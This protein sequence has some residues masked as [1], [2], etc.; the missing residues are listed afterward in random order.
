MPST[1]VQLNKWAVILSKI[2]EFCAEWLLCWRIWSLYWCDLRFNINKK[3]WK[4]EHVLQGSSSRAGESWGWWRLWFFHGLW[5]GLLAGMPLNRSFYFIASRSQFIYTPWSKCHFDGIQ[6]FQDVST[7]TLYFRRGWKST[8]SLPWIRQADPYECWRD[9]PRFSFIFFH[10]EEL[11]FIDD[12]EDF[13]FLFGE[14]E[15]LAESMR[16]RVL[17]LIWGL[18]WYAKMKL[19]Y[20]FLNLSDTWAK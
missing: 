4:L 14:W 2:V 15:F 19:Y 18:A 8:S 6:W 3:V 10:T 17:P 5:H 1:S 9:L 11:N 7:R 13:A 20:G 12:S 16:C